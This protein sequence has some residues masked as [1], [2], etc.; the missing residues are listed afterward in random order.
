MTISVQDI[1]LSQNGDS[2]RLIR[3]TDSGRVVVRHEANL[4]SGGR[5]MDMDVNW[6]LDRGASGPEHAALR[7]LLDNWTEEW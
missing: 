6:F 3:D 4:S 5:V 2:W 1:Y 7:R